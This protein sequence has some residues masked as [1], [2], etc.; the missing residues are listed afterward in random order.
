MEKTGPTVC[1]LSEIFNW[2][3]WVYLFFSLTAWLIG[4]VCLYVFSA[5]GAIQE[6][7]V[8]A[9]LNEQKASIL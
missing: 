9:V 6:A 3:Y 8:H 2:I 1:E 7:L 4:L 5:T